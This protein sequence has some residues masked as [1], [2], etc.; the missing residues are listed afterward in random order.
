VRS[1]H[2]F[3]GLIG[4][5]RGWKPEGD[6]ARRSVTEME[7]D[8]ALEYRKPRLIYSGGLPQAI[9]KRIMP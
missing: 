7:Y 1:A 9:A 2:I 8:W 6:T 5:Y 3:A 4:T